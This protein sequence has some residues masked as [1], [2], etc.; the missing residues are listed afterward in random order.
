[1][2]YKA[3]NITDLKTMILNGSVEVFGNDII[4][5][6]SFIQKNSANSLMGDIKSVCMTMGYLVSAKCHG[7]ECNNHVQKYQIMVVNKNRIDIPFHQAKTDRITLQRLYSRT[8]DVMNGRMQ[9]VYGIVSCDDDVKVQMVMEP[10]V[11]I[12]LNLGAVIDVN[13]CGEEN[14]IYYVIHRKPDDSFSARASRVNYSCF[15]AVNDGN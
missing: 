14:K 1:M 15:M 6:N 13:I 12:A 9:N 4:Y 2:S 7:D 10:F 8:K 5:N 3:F 11:T